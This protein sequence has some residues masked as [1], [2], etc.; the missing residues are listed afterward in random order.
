[1]HTSTPSFAADVKV[2]EALKAENPGS[3]IG[4]VGAAVAVAPEASL[5]ASAAL[6]FVAR[7]EF[8]F[9]VQEVAQG[10]PLARVAGLAYRERRPRRAHARAAGARGHGPRCPS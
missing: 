5:R 4:I 3:S 9:T 7:S 1:M 8:D 10:R 2:A 6:D